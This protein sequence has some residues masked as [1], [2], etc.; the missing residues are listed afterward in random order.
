MTRF[1]AKIDGLLHSLASEVL[2]VDDVV[3][4]AHTEED[5]QVLMDLFSRICTAFGLT[6]NLK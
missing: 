1:N 5:T 6:I 3:L 2:S 4:V